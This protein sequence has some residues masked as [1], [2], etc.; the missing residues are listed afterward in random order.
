MENKSH[1]ISAVVFIFVFGI[2]A[3]VFYYWIAPSE[4]GSRRYQIITDQAVGG[5]SPEA[6]VQFKGLKAGHVESVQYAPH[7]PNKVQIVFVVTDNIPMTTSTYAQLHTQGI[8][9]NKSL[10]LSNPKPKAQPLKT[11]ANHPAR[12]SLRPGLLAQLEKSGKQDMQ[13]I[14]TVLNNA[15]QLLSNQNRQ[16][17]TQAIAQI[18]TATQRLT[19]AEAT[20]QP[21]L[22]QLPKLTRQ[23][24]ATLAKISRL[25]EAAHKP[26][27][28]ASDVENSAQSLSQSAQKAIRK[29]NYDTLPKL[30]KLS[31]TISQ[32]ANQFKRLARELQA[33]P[34][35]LLLGPPQ[36]Q[37]GPGESGF[38]K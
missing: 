23:M 38:N 17:L 11:S 14:N 2:G 33:K 30:T 21:A 34:Q 16:H 27:A 26:I 1:V 4:S 7:N 31:E 35:S 22:T 8:T 25:A 20:V 37:P 18:D 19:A 6:T 5:L 13:K 29:L 12:I 15:A 9:G 10:R 28:Q 36:E 24:H 32:T 3:V